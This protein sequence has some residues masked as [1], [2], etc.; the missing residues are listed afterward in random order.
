MGDRG[1]IKINETGGLYRH[2]PLVGVL[3]AWPNHARAEVWKITGRPIRGQPGKTLVHDRRLGDFVVWG[4]RL[5]GTDA[6]TDMLL[7]LAA[8]AFGLT[9]I[10]IVFL[11]SNPAR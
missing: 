5:H 4:G 1:Y 2:C 6:A 7:P 11:I 8:V 3:G 10:V 9:A